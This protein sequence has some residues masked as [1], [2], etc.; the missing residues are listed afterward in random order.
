MLVKSS[1]NTL[2]RSRTETKGEAVT[3]VPNGDQNGDS[4]QFARLLNPSVVIFFK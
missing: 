4:G 3:I 2:P 1:L